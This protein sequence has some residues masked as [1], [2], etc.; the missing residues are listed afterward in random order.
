MKTK[1]KGD[2]IKLKF[3]KFKRA[4]VINNHY[5]HFSNKNPELQY[6]SEEL[7]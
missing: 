5:L 1:E 3:S 2:F 7:H 4:I 6:N